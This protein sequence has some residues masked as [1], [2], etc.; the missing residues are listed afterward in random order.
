[1]CCARF[2]IGNV[3]LIPVHEKS[4][5]LQDADSRG[6]LIGKLRSAFAQFFGGNCD[7]ALVQLIPL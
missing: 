6:K 4:H 2:L 7:S 3:G 1:M 5:L